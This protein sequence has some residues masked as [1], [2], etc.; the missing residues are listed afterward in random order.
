MKASHTWV[1]L[2][3]LLIGLLTGCASVARHLPSDLPDETGVVQEIREP[4]GLGQP[5]GSMKKVGLLRILVR[6]DRKLP[7]G[8]PSLVLVTIGEDT[9]ILQV[10][11]GGARS[12]KH[13]DLREGQN[14]QAW[15]KD[16][17]EDSYP[18]QVYGRV[19]IVTD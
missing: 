6:G 12:I 7:S 19:V 1:L 18:A 3:F 16:G 13:S 15:L 14:V 11:S 8:D 2:S 4:G 10:K 5:D 17:V 9:Q